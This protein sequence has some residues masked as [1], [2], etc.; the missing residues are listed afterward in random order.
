MTSSPRTEDRPTEAAQPSPGAPPC[1]YDALYIYYLEG[2]VD[3]DA[4]SS[5]RHFLGNWK[6]GQSTFLFFS[7]PAPEAVEALL[8]SRPAGKLIDTF[9]FDYAQWQGNAV[10]PFQVGAI[11]VVPYWHQEKAGE[12]AVKE[13]HLLLLDPGVV[14]G[15][16]THPTTRDALKLMDSLFEHHRPRTVLDLG[17][18]SGILALAAV[19]LGS[20]KVLAVDLNPL[21]ARTAGKNIRIN[22]ME[23]NILA[24]QG[25]AKDFIDCPADLVIANIHYDVMQHLLLAKGLGQKRWVI[26]SGLM[27]SQAR[28]A[29]DVV[30]GRRFDIIETRI[31][32]GIWYTYLLKKRA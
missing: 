8:Q 25:D 21:A 7:R 27:R 13:G 31:H 14:F 22:R 24:I 32:E 15:A 28:A 3:G 4:V 29:T 1:P 17:T 30:E 19:L 12:G 26:L 9:R 6:E 10:T 5:H 16:G 20:E 23:E 2:P 11:R 18:G